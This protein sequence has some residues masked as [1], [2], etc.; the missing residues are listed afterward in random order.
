M[1]HSNLIQKLKKFPPT[2]Q[3]RFYCPHDK[4]FYWF[5]DTRTRINLMEI[6]VT[7]TKIDI[8]QHVLSNH[9]YLIQRLTNAHDRLIPHCILHMG[10]V[11]GNLD[12]HN[13]LAKFEFK[14]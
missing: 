9:E 12:L 6:L 2:D 14:V 10:T 1:K 4:K 11:N 13:V 5:Y 3:V 7:D 8:P